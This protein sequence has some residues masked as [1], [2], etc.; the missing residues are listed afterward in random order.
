MFRNVLVVLVVVILIVIA[1]LLVYWLVIEPPPANPTATRVPTPVSAILER[2]TAQVWHLPSGKTEHEVES[3]AIARQHDRVR[4]EED[5]QA[6]LKWRDLHVRLY[7]DGEMQV[8]NVTPLW[9]AIFLDAGTALSG[10]KRDPGERLTWNTEY[11]EL[12]LEGTT[13]QLTYDPAAKLTLVRVFDGQLE[14]KNLTGAS[15]S[16]P[17][18][19]GEWAQIEPENP[20]YVSSDAQELRELVDDLGLGDLFHRVEREVQGGFGPVEAQ[21]SAGAVDLW[22]LTPTSTPIPR[23]S[24]TPTPTPD[25]RGPSAP[26]LREPANRTEVLCPTGD[27]VT[28]TLGWARPDDDSGIG[29]YDVEVQ[30]DEDALGLQTDTMRIEGDQL[31]ALFSARCATSY[32]WRVRAADG[33]GNV[34]DWSL[35]R[36]FRVMSL[37]ESDSQPPQAPTD[38]QPGSTLEDYPQELDSCDYLALAW[39]AAYDGLYGSGID[40]YWVNLQEKV[41]TTWQSI[42]SAS[43][44]GTYRDVRTVVSDGDYRWQVQAKDVAGHWGPTSEWRYFQC[45]DITAPPAP[46]ALG[47]GNP[48]SS[49]PEYYNCPWPLDWT[50]VSDPSGVNYHVVIERKLTDGTWQLVDYWYPV[51]ATELTVS[52]CSENVAYRWRVRARDGV[53][54]W[55]D[56]SQYLYHSTTIW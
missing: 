53:G 54:N 14:V 2:E 18:G 33:A 17:V 21:L 19:I 12:T 47:P 48:D 51:S 5:G 30:W 55:G 9:I 39:S 40:Y 11:A 16:K 36:E 8:R 52:S 24:D 20:P 43:E 38:L 56:W 23:P 1:A 25:V 22:F 13:F 42:L 6:L 27:D 3:T 45:P 49:D 26:T 44:D 29:W 4:T 15:E 34:G 7:R 35:T 50:S 46:V 28:V 10:G 41:G 31:Q 37:V 32:E